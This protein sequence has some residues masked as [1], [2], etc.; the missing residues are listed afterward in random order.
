MQKFISFIGLNDSDPSRLLREGSILR[1]PQQVRQ[2]RYRLRNLPR[3]LSRQ[4]IASVLVVP[5]VQ[6]FPV[7]HT[8]DHE[9]ARVNDESIGFEGPMLGPCVRHASRKDSSLARRNAITSNNPS[10][11]LREGNC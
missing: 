6:V 8:G 11:F 1:A 7:L 2:P 4:M 3:F 5:G 9:A 10:R